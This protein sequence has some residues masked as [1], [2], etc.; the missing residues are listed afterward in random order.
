MD[1]NKQIREAAAELLSKIDGRLDE[2]KHFDE[3]IELSRKL[4]QWLKYESEISP[5]YERIANQLQQTAQQMIRK[6]KFDEAH[7]IIDAYHRIYTGNLS[8]DDAITALSEN[9]L[10]N[11]STED[12]LDILLKDSSTD[13]IS[14]Q[15]KDIHSLI[16]MGTTTVERLLDRLHDSHNRAERRRIIEVITKIGNPAITPVVERL[17]QEGPWFYLRNLVLLLGR[18]GSDT[19]LK[20]LESILMHEDL[21]VQREAVFA[22]QAID[23]GKTGEIILRNIY[24]VGQENFGLMISVLGLLKYQGA[25]STLIEMLESGSPVSRKKDKNEVMIKICEALGKIGNEEAIRPLKNVM[26]TKGFLSIRSVDPEI[27][28]AAKEAIERIK[29]KIE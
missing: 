11:I 4:T 23:A 29:K 20:L 10:Q 16:I 1:D 7:E 26:R 2:S 9:M 6:E 19:H 22:I 18:I 8:K 15:K 3:K 12:I 13:E 5:V 21:R 27:R 17:R 25:V 14:R 28:D 24:T